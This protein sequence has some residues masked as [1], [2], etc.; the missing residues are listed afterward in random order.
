M[1]KQVYE[2]GGALNSALD[3]KKLFKN[4]C[5]ESLVPGSDDFTQQPTVAQSIAFTPEP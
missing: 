4:H 2:D 1:E 5:T 3:A